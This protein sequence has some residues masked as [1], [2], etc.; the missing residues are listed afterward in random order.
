MAV[1]NTVN[2]EAEPISRHKK[3][4]PM[5]LTLCMLG[6]FECYFVAVCQLLSKQTFSKNNLSRTLLVS[7][8]GRPDLG[9]NCLQQ[10]TSADDKSESRNM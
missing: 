9:P 7:N 1:I 10:T 3:K 8:A 2:I 6:N 4:I 5:Y